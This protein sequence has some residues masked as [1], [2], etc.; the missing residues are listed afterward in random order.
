MLFAEACKLGRL[1]VIKNLIKNGHPTVSLIRSAIS[2]KIEKTKFLVKHGCDVD[3]VD[4]YGRTA[5]SIVSNN[6]YIEMVNLLIELGADVNKVNENDNNTPLHDASYNGNT[7]IIKLLINAGAD[8]NAINKNNKTPIYWALMNGHAE[9]VKVFI[10]AGI[11]VN[12]CYE[13]NETA[14]NWASYRGHVETVKL[15]IDACADVNIADKFNRTPLY[16]A[17]CVEH[18]EITHLLLCEHPKIVKEL[19]H[20]N[21]PKKLKD[22]INEYLSCMASRK[23]SVINIAK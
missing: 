21:T 20:E 19:L 23:K 9:T 17:L 1:D 7:E 22:K 3:M 18:M 12:T 14:L 13:D 11:D 5:L 10:D 2:C 16:W 8:V 6:G 15:L 4:E